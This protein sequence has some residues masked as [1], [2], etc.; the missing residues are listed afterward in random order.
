MSVKSLLGGAAVTALALAIAAPAAAQEKLVTA[1]YKSGTQQYFIDQAEGFEAAANELGYDSR[2]INV[3]LDSNLAISAVSDAIAAGARGIGITAPDQALGP[4]VAAAAADADVALVATDDRLQD[5]GGQDV[6]F[7]GFDGVDMGTRVGKAAA[8]LLGESSW[9]NDASYGVLSVEVQT[10]SVCN[11]RTDAARAQLADIGVDADRFIAVPYDGTA[12]KA[13]EAA[14]PAITAN[15]SVDKW[16]VFAC[17]DEG[18]LG[19]VNALQN[20]GYGPD[21]GIAVGLGAYEA[22]R[23]WAAGVP[24]MFKAALYLSGADVGDA[25]ARA[26]INSIESGDP[27]P[28]NTVANT[29]IVTPE[30][31]ADVMPCG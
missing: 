10:L 26:L 21:D 12:N 27:L 25:A 24:T 6:P 31:Y 3:E 9:M 19:T 29:T 17:N 4:A 1:I 11:D 23:P 22:C 16:V 7:V 20:A 15:P 13:L 8:E 30:T 18:V 2:I 28:P 5:G 14:G